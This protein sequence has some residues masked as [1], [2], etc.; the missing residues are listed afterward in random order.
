M[1]H[2]PAL[3]RKAIPCLYG[4]WAPDFVGGIQP[5]LLARHGMP[6]MFD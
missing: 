5:A 2:R 3:L 4:I 6:T 1:G